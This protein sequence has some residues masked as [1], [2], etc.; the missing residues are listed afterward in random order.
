MGVI[1]LLSPSN[2]RRYCILGGKSM[3]NRGRRTWPTS[4]DQSWEKMWCKPSFPTLITSLDLQVF[5]GTYIHHRGVQHP[6]TRDSF[7]LGLPRSEICDISQLW[8]LAW[9][10]VTALEE[11]GWDVTQGLTWGSWGSTRFI[12]TTFSIPWAV[13][14][15]SNILTS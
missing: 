2:F 4:Y 8:G 6:W 12:V 13:E 14:P 10:K 7:P 11:C 1:T 9:S 3:K 15:G 5:Q